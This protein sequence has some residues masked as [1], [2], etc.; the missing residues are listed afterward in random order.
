MFNRPANPYRLLN[1]HGATV[2]LPYHGGRSGRCSNGFERSPPGSGG[3]ASTHRGGRRV[4][5]EESDPELA[6][7]AAPRDAY[8]MVGQQLLSA[9]RNP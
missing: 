2:A 1:C 6:A 5:A 9:I 4:V 3:T 8:D 7:L